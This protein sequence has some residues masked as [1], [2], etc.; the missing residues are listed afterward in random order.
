[1]AYRIKASDYLHS[2]AEAEHVP[3]G[4]V[5]VHNR[6]RP[7]KILSWEGFRAWTQPLDETLEPCACKWAGQNAD[8][9]LRHYRTKRAGQRA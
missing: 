6:V 1:M 7:R 5:L 2:M 9:H 4:R 8:G 3:R